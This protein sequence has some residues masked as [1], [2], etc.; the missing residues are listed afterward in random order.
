MTCQDSGA[1]SEMCNDETRS[2][3]VRIVVPTLCYG[4]HQVLAILL[5]DNINPVVAV[6]R[7]DAK[8]ETVGTRHRGCENACGCVVA[9][10]KV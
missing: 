7:S 3:V 9:F 2:L 10:A 1:S 6:V 8:K 5:Q 4:M